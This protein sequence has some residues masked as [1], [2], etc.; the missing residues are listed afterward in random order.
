M[1]EFDAKFQ[2]PYF[3]HHLGMNYY[4]LGPSHLAWADFEIKVKWIVHYYSA[5][6]SVE[7]TD[8]KNVI[9]ENIHWALIEDAEVAEV[10]RPRNSK[11]R[12]FYYEK[13]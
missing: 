13:W 11:R 4:F 6:W 3:P 5:F 1:L 10:K 9:V 12:K 8:F 7:Q 2:I